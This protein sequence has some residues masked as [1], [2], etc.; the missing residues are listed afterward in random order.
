MSDPSKSETF[1]VVTM[2]D[3]DDEIYEATEFDGSVTVSIKDVSSDPSPG[4]TITTSSVKVN[5]ISE[6]IPEVSISAP[7]TT[8]SE[9]DQVEFYYHRD[10]SM[11]NKIFCRSE[12]G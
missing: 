10:G 9:G 6:D 8:A 7:A 11:G 1:E 5:V 12:C 2:T 4:Y 3:T